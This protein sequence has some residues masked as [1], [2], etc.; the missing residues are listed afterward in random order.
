MPAIRCAS[1]TVCSSWCVSICLPWHLMTRI[2]TAHRVAAKSAPWHRRRKKYALGEGRRCLA[3]D[4]S[5]APK[6]SPSQALVTA[7]T[8]APPD[9]LKKAIG[10]VLT[11]GPRQDLAQW[12]DCWQGKHAKL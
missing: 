11:E 10:E 12:L 5:T 9:G 3:P 6:T 4:S 1:S 8:K 7:S 2:S